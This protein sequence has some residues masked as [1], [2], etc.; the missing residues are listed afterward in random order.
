M[1]NLPFKEFEHNRVWLAIVQ[2]AHDLLI[3]M[4]QLLFTG[5]LARSEPKRL[6]YRILHVAG[7]LPSTPARDTTAAGRLA[8]GRELTSAFERLA[9]LPAP[10]G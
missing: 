3:W 2:I 9:A 8:L 1:R 10:S 5:K 4:K 7:A 6:R